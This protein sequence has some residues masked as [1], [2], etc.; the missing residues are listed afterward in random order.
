MTTPL[1]LT[2]AALG[3]AAAGLLAWRWP[4]IAIVGV[5]LA[6]IVD[7]YLISLALPPDQR[8]AVPYLSEALLAV[9][10]LVVLVHATRRRTLRAGLDHPALWLLGAFTLVAAISALV[11][12]VPVVV[13][14]TGIVFTVEAVALFVLVRLVPFDVRQARLAVAALCGLV[15]VAAALAMGQVLVHPDFL[16]LESFA[17]RFGEGARVTG[18]L[19]N[20]NMLGAM[21]A[22]ALP[23]SVLFAVHRDG[24]ARVAAWSLSL[25]LSLALLYTFSRGAWFALALA[26]LLVGVVVE[27]RLLLAMVVLAVVTFS[28]AMVLPRHLAYPERG[29]ERFDLIAATLGRLEA[30][31]EGDLRVQFVENALPIVADHPLIGAG[32][33][34]YGGAVARNF[35]SPLYQTYT[36]GTVPRDRTV[37]NFWL[38]L[39][40]E[41]GV[42]GAGLLLAAIGVVVTGVLRAG[43][44]ADGDRRIL[45][46]GNAA[47]AVVL[48]VASL[49]E[50][51]LEGNTTTFAM[52]LLLGMATGLA[53]GQ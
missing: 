19:V 47:V 3:V 11:N 24:P 13:A 35:G 12:A 42:V 8:T 38:H 28:I 36:A 20:P 52:W 33:G 6:P 45:L 50:M 39:L 21:L 25:L 53:E 10:A 31:G 14:I 44:A 48:G 15:A 30:L 34:R 43:R 29:Q 18:F 49:T 9:V 46:A 4:R 41:A 7:R 17:G 51:L 26:T 22:M 2:V 16:G 32:P 1:L 37:D 27:R 40:V 5:A 23:F